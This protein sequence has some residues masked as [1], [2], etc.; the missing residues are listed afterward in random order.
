MMLRA[1]LQIQLWQQ[2]ANPSLLQA[3][4]LGGLLLTTAAF[5]AAA[6]VF[7]RRPQSAPR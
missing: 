7:A 5:L 6:I 2:L 1:R 4:L 3:S